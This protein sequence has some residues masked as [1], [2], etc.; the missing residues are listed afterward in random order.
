MSDPCEGCTYPTNCRCFIT[1]GLKM[2]TQ[3]ELDKII[4]DTIELNHTL[5]Q[6]LGEFE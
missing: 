6:F 2:P 1:A 3:Q 5:E 4:C